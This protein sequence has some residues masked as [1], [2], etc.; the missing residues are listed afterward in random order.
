MIKRL[1]VLS[2]AVLFATAG[3]AGAQDAYSDDDTVAV[4]DT[5]VEPGQPV[6]VSARTYCA[7]C[8][9]TFTL[10]SEPVVLGTVDADANGVATLT[11]TVPEGTSAGT[12]TIEATGTGA[13]GLPLTV[14][15]TITVVAPG[16][17]GT[18]SGALPTTG[19]DSAISMTQIALAAVV[20]GGLLVL[21]AS[22]RRANATAE[23]ETASL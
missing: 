10:F 21:A 9:V 3:V 6:T 5:A 20:G 1:L 22:K 14:R 15:T 16:A 19:S 23:R 7:G 11:F 17:A 2:A 4:S 8:P 13:D 18:G 12:H